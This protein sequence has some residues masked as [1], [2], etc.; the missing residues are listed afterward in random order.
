MNLQNKVCVDTN[1]KYIIIK[2]AV[3]REDSH[4]N[5]ESLELHNL[6]ICQQNSLS[7]LYSISAWNLQYI[8]QTEQTYFESMSYQR[9]LENQ[10]LVA[11]YDCINL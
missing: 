6:S 8:L 3:I 9:L 5:M 2:Y 7:V 11:Q 1:Y 10:I 4:V